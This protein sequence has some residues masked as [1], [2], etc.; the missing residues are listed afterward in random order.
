MQQPQVQQRIVDVVSRV[1]EV[2]RKQLRLSLTLR[3][4]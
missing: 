4:I 3:S 1:L 2:D